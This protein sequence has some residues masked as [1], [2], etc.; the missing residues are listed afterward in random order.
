MLN[1]IPFIFYMT[2]I[3]HTTL[4]CQ[5]NDTEPQFIKETHVTLKA[6]ITINTV[7]KALYNKL[8]DGTSAQPYQPTDVTFFINPYA[9]IGFERHFAKHIAL[10]IN[11]GYYQTLQKYKS[12][13][14]SSASN[15]TSVYGSSLA[16]EISSET[17]YLNNNI[18]LELLPV[19]VYKHTRIL[20][21]L[22]ITRSSPTVYSTVTVTD[23][24]GQVI[25]H[26]KIKDMPEETYHAYSMVGILQGFKIGS[27][28]LTLSASYFGLLKK[29]DS[30][31]NMAIGFIF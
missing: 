5:T 22:N 20:G 10:H 1:K 12:V 15:P 21:G 7:N 14:Y 17:Q 3:G 26:D 25:G 19:Y 9:G 13:S 24:N 16:H 31:T 8:N 2:C 27:H 18:F 30:G 6:G 29:Y 28:E 4:C 23:F 11:V